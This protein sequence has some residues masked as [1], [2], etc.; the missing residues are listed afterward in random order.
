MKILI[1]RHG[2]PNYQIDGL[3]EKGKIEAE[4]VSKKLIKE[5]IKAIYSSPLGRARLTA[6]PTVEKTGITE[7][8]QP[9][10]REFT[11]AKIKVPY[12]AE[13][14]L[15]WDLLPEFVNTLEHIYHPTRWLEEDFI[16]NSEIPAY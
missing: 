10:L 16:K 3:T 4:L 5:D 12:F 2:D 9:W 8:I 11:V 15:C 13:E 1:V 6:A 7:E 14:R